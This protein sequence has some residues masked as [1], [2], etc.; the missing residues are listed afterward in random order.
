[1][2]SFVESKPD[3]VKAEHRNL[4]SVAYKN[5]VGSRRSAW[6]VL[7]SLEQKSEDSRSE[8]AK[9]R[10]AI[11]DELRAICTEVIVRVEFPLIC[12]QF[13]QFFLFF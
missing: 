2:K 10:K 11:E 1:M 9:Y 6:R 5:V 8:L 7:S 12:Q 3:D 4:L 13:A